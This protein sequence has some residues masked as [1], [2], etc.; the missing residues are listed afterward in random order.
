MFWPVSADGEQLAVDRVPRGG[1]RGVECFQGVGPGETVCEFHASI[2]GA[3]VGYVR[4][5]G[6]VDYNPFGSD[7]LAD[8][9]PAYA[10]LR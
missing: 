7:V 10:E 6:E 1:V 9:F 4:S 3:A 5:V 2:V 8:P